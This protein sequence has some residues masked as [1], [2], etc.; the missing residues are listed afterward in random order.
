MSLSGSSF[1]HR[2]SKVFQ[3]VKL[4][5]VLEPVTLAPSIRID[6][7]LSLVARV[8]IQSR[9]CHSSVLNSRPSL[10]GKRKIIATKRIFRSTS[11]QRVPLIR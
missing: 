10:K 3:L 4:S 9:S 5:L 11:I 6:T 2:L 1:N 7:W 8:N